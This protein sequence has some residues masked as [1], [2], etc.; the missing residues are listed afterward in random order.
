M[1]TVDLLRGI[2][3]GKHDAKDLAREYEGSREG[4]VDYYKFLDD[5]KASSKKN[6]VGKVVVVVVVENDG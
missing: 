5:L 4:R 6:R 1:Q 3:V 2:N